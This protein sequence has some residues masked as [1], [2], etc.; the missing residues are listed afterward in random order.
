V[1]LEGYPVFK[2]YL[3]DV[4]GQR[5]LEVG[6]GSGRHGL[7]IAHDFPESHVVITDIV[8]DSL[9]LMARMRER[10]G[11]ANVEIRKEDAFHLSF[12]DRS[13]DVV[14][15]DA[16]I[17]YLP[18]YAEAVKEMARTLKPGGRLIISVVNLL[19]FP[20]LWNKRMLGTRYPHGYEKS[21]TKKE[22]RDLSASAGLRVVGQ[23]GFYFAYGISRLKS[24]GKIYKVLGYL[25]NCLVHLIDPLIGRVISKYF[26]FY[27]VIVAQK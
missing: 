9:A 7:K 26:G 20:H 10:L 11:I 1:F 22:L 2:K 4:P 15:C 13:F 25:I 17:E 21:F 3:P 8:D 14:F 6:G 12:P 19:N 27:I 18:N 24:Y 23:D 5:I 16:V